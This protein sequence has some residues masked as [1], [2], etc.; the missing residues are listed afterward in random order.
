VLRAYVEKYFLFKTILDNEIHR[1][2]ENGR[3]IEKEV[4]IT[5]IQVKEG[6]A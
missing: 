5:R 2:D 6:A 4:E 3:I 1:T